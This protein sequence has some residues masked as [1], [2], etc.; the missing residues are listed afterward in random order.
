VP[1]WDAAGVVERVGPAVTGVG[2]GDEVVG[3]IRRDDVQYGT[4]AE[5]V[6]APQ[7][8]VAPKAAS[9]SMVEAA[10]LPLAGL[11]AYQALTEAIGVQSGER[12]LIHAAAGGV[13]S[14]AVQLAKTLGAH[15]IGTASKDNHDYLRDLGADEVLDYRDGPISEQLDEK[16]DAVLDL[17]GGDALRDAPQQVH[18]GGRIASVI[19]PAT[20]LELGGHYVFV[21]PDQAQLSA[22][23]AYVES[24]ALRV[25][26]DETFPLE[27]AADAHRRVEAGHGRGKVVLDVSAE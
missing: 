21:R 14:M 10:G 3:Y 12:L 24:G 23:G 5:L 7:R 6:P 22:L 8:C 13:G 20:V 11:T 16:A 17:V 1:G 2:V 27:R 25:I 9:Q 19:D 18:R 4:Y 26:V 15:V